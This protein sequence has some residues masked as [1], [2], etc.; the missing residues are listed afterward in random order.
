MFR[1]PDLG[2]PADHPDRGLLTSIARDLDIPAASLMLAGSMAEYVRD[3]QAWRP[4]LR[5]AGAQ[6]ALTDRFLAPLLP[7][8]QALFLEVRAE[9]DPFLRQAKPA[10]GEAP[11]P[12]GQCLEI[13]E[14]VRARLETLDAARLTAPAARAFAALRDFRAAGGELRRAWGDLRGEYFQNAL[15]VGALYVDV[16]NDTVVVTKPPVEILPFAEAGFRPVA[17]YPHYMRIAARYWKLRFLPNHF[18]PDL[19]PYLPL[20]QIAPSGGMRIGP[21]DPYM[22]G[23]NLGGRFLPSQ[24]ALAAAPLSPATFASL[25]AAMHDGPLPVAP[26]PEQGRAAALARCRTWRAEGRFDCAATFNRAIAAARQLN[27]RLA[28]VVAVARP[29]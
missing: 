21:L 5:D 26:D 29:A 7:G 6:Q 13:A 9:L 24:Q 28:G 12:I 2:L 25:A 18:L 17:D 27:R 1:V 3:T 10:R 8:L 22:L 11:Y 19:A 14:A 20:I 23:L 16:A 4:E 15:I